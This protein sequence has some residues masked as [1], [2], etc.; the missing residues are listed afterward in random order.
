MFMHLP[1]QIL[2]SYLTKYENIL[3]G[4]STTAQKINKPLHGKNQKYYFFTCFSKKRL[5]FFRCTYT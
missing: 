5:R 3:N 2:H 4:S 1:I